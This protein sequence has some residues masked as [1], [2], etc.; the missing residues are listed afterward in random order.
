MNQEKLKKPECLFCKIIKGELPATKIYEDEKS[1]AFLNINPVNPG[2]SLVI[3]KEHFSNIYDT[4][5]EIMAHLIKVSKKICLA[6]KVLETDGVN[7]IENNNQAAGQVIFHTHLHLIPRF[8]KDGLVEWPG[9][10]PY[11]TGEAEKIAK[12]IIANL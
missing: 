4:P 2:H 6:L 11:K 7:I 9:N 8:A 1:F 10:G 3:P 12:K 5:E